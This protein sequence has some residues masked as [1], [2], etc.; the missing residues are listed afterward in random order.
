MLYVEYEWY[1]MRYEG[2]LSY[3]SDHDDGETFEHEILHAIKRKIFIWL[4]HLITILSGF[5]F[6]CSKYS[7]TN[8]IILSPNLSNL[9]QLVWVSYIISSS[10]RDVGYIQLD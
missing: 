1:Y 8:Y 7:S 3:P 5:V 4:V 2:M 9:F 10:M 6:H